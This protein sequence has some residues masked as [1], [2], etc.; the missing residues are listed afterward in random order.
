MSWTLLI[1]LV[2]LLGI[3]LFATL[4]RRSE[5]ASMQRTI[6]ERDDAVA[7]GTDR[8]KLQHPVVDLSRCLGC[9]TCVAV[10]PEDDVLE[11]VH[12]QA[13]VINGSRCMGI[14][15][16][17]RE[18]PVGAITVTIDNL[19][20]RDDVPVLDELEAV[21]TPGLFLAG[22]VTAHALIRTAI[23]HGTAVGSAVASRRA[24]HERVLDLCVVGAGPAGISCAL[25]A[26]RRGLDFV[27]L[28]QEAELGGTIAKYPRRKLVLAEPVDVP[29]HGRLKKSSYRKEEL[30]RLW[31]RLA[32]EHELPIRTSQV[33]RGLERD[34]EGYFIVETT[35][36][37]FRAQNVCLAIGRRGIPRKL[38]VPGEDLPHVTYSLLDARSFAGRRVLVVGGGDSAVEAALGLAE[39]DGTSVTLACRSDGFPRIRSKN[40]ERL[41]AAQSA[42]RLD[43]LLESQ[44]VEIRERDVELSLPMRSSMSTWQDAGTATIETRTL[45]ID[46][47]FVMAGGTPPFELLARSGVSFDPTL[48]PVQAPIEEQGTGAARALQIAFALALATLLWALWHVDYYSLGIAERPAHVKHNQLRPG[49]GLGLW[50]GFAATMLIGVNLLYVLRRSPRFGWRFG[51][52]RVWMTSHVATGVL[53]FLLTIL[54]AGLSP[55]DTPGGH[56]FWALAIL[57]VTGSI[58]RYLYAWIPRAANGREL[59]LAEVK[60]QLRDADESDF[61]V[62]ARERIEE[63]VRARQW[64]GTFFGR[65][66]ALFG[67][68]RDLR[69]TLR[70]L[71]KEGTDRGISKVRVHRT[72]A[73]ARRAHRIALSVAHFEDLRAMLGTWRWVHRW[74]AALMVLLLVIH[75]VH[76]LIYGTFMLGVTATTWGPAR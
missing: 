19:E 75:V 28:E 6:D 39:Q 18:C 22:E 17:E 58:G 8:A 33:F 20:E 50:F 21:G 52:L 4:S 53:A 46:D 65:V 74:G 56:A 76:A 9:G 24:T 42:A 47:V 48:R 26:K 16:C 15:A 5:L 40:A 68:R 69:R 45:E 43:V 41:E 10:C 51:S 59:D 67:V 63:L 72:L 55:R 30:M 34:P 2:L 1:G 25:E 57:V 13:V 49:M 7:R 71:R 38:D 37:R 14:A 31:S 36:D 64:G 32:R 11:I 60:A 62:I 35:R 3:A 12:G 54:H 61:D 44:V 66:T 29:L 23:E 73:L 70:S 27:V